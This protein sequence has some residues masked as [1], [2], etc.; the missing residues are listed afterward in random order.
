MNVMICFNFM[1]H[2]IHMQIVDLFLSL[3]NLPT[4]G[5]LLVIKADT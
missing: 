1:I 3:L 5:D 2:V 4:D